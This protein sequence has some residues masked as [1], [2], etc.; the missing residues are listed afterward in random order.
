[1]SDLRAPAFS[2]VLLFSLLGLG[3][4]IGVGLRSPGRTSPLCTTAELWRSP[5]A[6]RGHSDVRQ[7]NLFHA[8]SLGA[9][10]T[11]VTDF[12]TASGYKVVRCPDDLR[13]LPETSPRLA[14]CRELQKEFVCAPAPVC[15]GVPLDCA[16]FRGFAATPDERRAWG[17]LC[18]GLNAGRD[19]TG[20]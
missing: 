18:V 14:L 13:R 11:A 8:V 4:L 16:A 2:R 3:F 5:E 19:L 1:M 15:A 20:F 6:L 9:G 17:A 7:C 10:E 12:Y